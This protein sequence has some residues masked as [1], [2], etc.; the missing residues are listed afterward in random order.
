MKNREQK[1][2]GKMPHLNEPQMGEDSKTTLFEQRER[3]RADYRWIS[4]NRDK[5]TQEFLN[6]YVAV[7]D[8]K[9]VASDEDAPSLLK[10]LRATGKKPDKFAVEYFSE[11]PMC[12]L[13]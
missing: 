8:K 13:L 6:K 4:D 11:H 2:T 12:Y 9:V 7:K 3:L 5:L 1:R 10:Q